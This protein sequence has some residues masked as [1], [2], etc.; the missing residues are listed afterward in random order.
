MLP[1]TMLI[2]SPGSPVPFT[3]SEVR[4]TGSVGSTARTGIVGSTGTE[5]GPD[6]KLVPLLPSVWVAVIE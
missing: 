4:P 5:S 6:G 1:E 3:S 2:L